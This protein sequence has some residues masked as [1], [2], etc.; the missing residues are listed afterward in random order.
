MATYSL[1]LALVIVPRYPGITKF[2]ARQQRLT[3]SPIKQKK[4]KKKKKKTKK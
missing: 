4:K 2:S 1:S 3:M